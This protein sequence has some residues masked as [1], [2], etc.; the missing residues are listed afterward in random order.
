MEELCE[1]CY[2]VIYHLFVVQVVIG[3]EVDARVSHKQNAFYLDHWQNLLDMEFMLEL[4]LFTYVFQATFIELDLLVGH[5]STSL[6]SVC[7]IVETLG[8]AAEYLKD[9]LALVMELVA[10]C[11]VGREE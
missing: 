6:V 1:V 3:L 2:L 10:C 8:H 9:F 7:C 5:D 11:N 4:R